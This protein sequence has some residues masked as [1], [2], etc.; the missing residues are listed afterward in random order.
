MEEKREIGLGYFA[1]KP[2]DTREI[3]A[4]HELIEKFKSDKNLSNYTKQYLENFYNMVDLDYVQSS[5]RLENIQYET[6]DKMLPEIKLA[7][8]TDKGVL[9]FVLPS[10]RK[11]LEDKTKL[12]SLKNNTQFKD[13]F[14]GLIKRDDFKLKFMT[15]GEFKEKCATIGIVP[16]L[17][18]VLPNATID[19]V[20]LVYFDKEDDTLSVLPNK[21]HL[22]ALKYMVKMANKNKA[23]NKPLTIDFMEKLSKIMFMGTER[24]NVQ[25]FGS[26]RKTNV[27]VGAF[28]EYW[29]TIV[30]KEVTKRDDL[31]NIIEFDNQPIINE[32]QKL[33]D[34]FNNESNEL[35]LVERAAVLNLEIARLQP[36]RD[37][38]KRVSRLLT[39][40]C[41]L[42]GGYPTVAFVVNDKEYFE[43]M[44]LTGMLKVQNLES[45]DNI[46]EYIGSIKYLYLFYKRI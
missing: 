31:G 16:K 38:N 41:L 6:F 22:L 21:N 34:W 26:I 37:G 15:S 12:L 33:F 11:D 43:K 1:S 29:K 17:S 36:F 42:Q 3:E 28:E 18:Y 5:D 7:L 24:A 23:Q 19:N 46:M 30:L 9:D 13:I 20:E 27:R 14:T 39:N 25:G 8:I 35:P 4:Q 2:C 40:Y 32:V 44:D 10:E 45:K